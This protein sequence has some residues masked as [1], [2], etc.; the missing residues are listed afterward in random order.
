M[1]PYPDVLTLS[2]VSLKV[3]PLKR[4]L[5]QIFPSI[6]SA[7]ENGI[8]LEVFYHIH[9]K[10]IEIQGYIVNEKEAEGQN[11]DRH[12]ERFIYDPNGYYLE[13]EST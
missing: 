13:I 8:D 6:D 7:P 4:Q 10:K 3:D 5:V 2:K 11:M 9:N 1:L 12:N